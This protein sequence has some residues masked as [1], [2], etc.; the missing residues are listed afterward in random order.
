MGET[1]TVIVE[2]LSG[3]L[4]PIVLMHKGVFFGCTGNNM[5][6]NPFVCQRENR[7]HCLQ[8]LIMITFQ[9]L[10]MF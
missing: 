10:K 5:S 4:C 8:D 9:L 3:Y 1:S 7:I 6:V 2:G